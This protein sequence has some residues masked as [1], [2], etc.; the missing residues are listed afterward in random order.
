MDFDGFDPKT[1]TL[2]EAKARGYQKWF[3]EELNPTHKFYEGVEGMVRQARRQFQMAAGRP[4]RWHV[5]EPRM[6][7][8]LQKYFEARGLKSIEVV[9]T[10]P[11]K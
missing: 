4:I 11:V 10:P 7:A 1:G 5:A 3:D 9:Y 8:V 6:V 2:I